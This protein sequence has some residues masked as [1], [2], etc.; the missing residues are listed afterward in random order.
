[1]IE[2]ATITKEEHQTLQ[3]EFFN[4]FI[5]FLLYLMLSFTAF[6]IIFYKLV[7]YPYIRYFSIAI[8]AFIFIMIK[9][10]F[11]TWID[12]ISVEKLVLNGIVVNKYMSM[13]A[14]EYYNSIDYY[15]LIDAQSDKK[16]HRFKLNEYLY[17]CINQGDNVKISLSKKLNKVISIE[18]I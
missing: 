3:K 14:K 4:E 15:V 16:I 6:Y 11:N 12:S 7:D 8:L 9:N 18:T 5:I 2:K 13:K 17:N 1:M 10:L